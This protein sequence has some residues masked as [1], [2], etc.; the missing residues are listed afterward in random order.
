MVAPMPLSEKA[1]IAQIRRMAESARHLTDKSR[2]TGVSAPHG[3]G[4]ADRA[5]PTQILTGIGDD[6]AVLRVLP[7]RDFLLTTDFTLEGIHFRR[8]WH[9]AE[10]VG[11]RCLAR[12][13]SDIAAMGGEPVAAF[14]SL[15]LP[16]D[17]PQAWVERFM[18]GLLALAQK[19]DV[20]LAGGDTAE[21]PNGILADITVVGSTPRGKS[22]LRSAA[23]P[24]DRIFVSGELGGSAAAVVEMRAKS[25]RVK[26]Q[27]YSRHFYPEPR[28]ELG[29]ILRQKG[30][31][32][33][34]I[35]LSDGL[36]TDLAHI[37]EESGVGAEIES[38]LIPRAR[39]GKPTREVHLDLALHGGEDYELL[40]TAP[41]GKRVPAQI[42]RVPLTRIGSITR[43]R[44]I[45][46]MN[47]KGIGY[48]LVARGWEHFRR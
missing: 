11:Y 14:L 40:F 24:G 39:V 26:P 23:R 28:V 15:A 3:Q 47:P 48:E 34:M 36:S 33:A 44:K 45:F 30:L 42:A 21:S 10:S 37:C 1:L 18:R 32:S 27:D 41:A 46:V 35:D 31:A 20:T 5:R 8:D 13:L 19:Y 12:G 16:R 25:R 17:L 43:G 22:V 29:R 6:C 38:Q 7:D 9:P 4:Q 2:R